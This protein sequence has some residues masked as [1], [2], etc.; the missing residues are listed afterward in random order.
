MSS[1]LFEDPLIQ[2]LEVNGINHEV[3]AQAFDILNGG[4]MALMCLVIF[5]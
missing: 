2:P 4:M 1:E 3:K 5:L